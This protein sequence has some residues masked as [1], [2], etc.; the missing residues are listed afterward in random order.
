MSNLYY[1][2]YILPV[3]GMI[4]FILLSIPPVQMVIQD[5]IPDKNYAIFISSLL[6]LIILFI[7]CRIMDLVWSEGHCHDTVCANAL[8]IMAA[9]VQIEKEVP[10]NQEAEPNPTPVEVEAEGITPAEVEAEGVT[11]AE[12]KEI[13]SNVTE[14]LDA[15]PPGAEI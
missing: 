3:V 10:I 4:S 1:R 2:C 13:Q 14:D 12:L 9:Q 8:A 7:T 5:W 11:P 15:A 6:V